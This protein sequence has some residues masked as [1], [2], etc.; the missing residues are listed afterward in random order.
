MLDKG[1]LLVFDGDVDYKTHCEMNLLQLGCAEI[2][3]CIFKADVY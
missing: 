1:R 2:L 3:L